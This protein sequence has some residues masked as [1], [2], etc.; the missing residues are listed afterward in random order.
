MIHASS[1][2]RVTRLTEYGPPPFLVEQVHLTVHLDVDPVLV[3][4]RLAI[5]RNPV[6]TPTPDLLLDGQELEMVALRLDGREPAAGSWMIDAAGNLLLRQVPDRF[7]LEVENRIH[8]ARNTSLEGLYLSN[9]RFCTQCEAEGFRKITWYLDR[10]DVLARFTV[11]LVAPCRGYPVLLA[12]GNRIAQG[13]LEGERHYATWE[14]PFPKPSYLF[15]MVAGDLA[16]ISGEFTTRSGRRVALHFYTEAENADRC[17]HALS[18]LK[19]AMAWDEIRFGREY[20]LDVYMIVAVNDFNM[21]AMEN[22]GLNIFNSQYVLAKP[23]TATD[24]DFQAIESVIAH[25]Y[26]HNWT[27]NRITCRDWFQLSLKE[28]LTVFRDQEFSADILSRGVQRIKDVRLL[29]TVQFA[30][31]SGPTAH[32]VQPDTYIEINNFYT[33]TIYNKGAEVVRMLHTLLGEADFRR[34]MDLYF[35]R[36]DG[37]AVTVD[38]FVRA[39]EEAS[40]RDFSQF[41]LWYRQAGT[42]I[43][44]AAMEYSVTT[45]MTT[46]TLSQETAPT[47]GQPD[48]KPLHIPVRVAL[49]GTTGEHLPLQDNHSAPAPLEMVLELREARQAFHF[50]GQAGLEQRPVVSILRGFSAP[51]RLEMARTDAELAFLWARDTDPFNRWDAGQE[52]LERWLFRWIGQY[53]QESRPSLVGDGAL[54]AAFLATLN[55]PGLDPAMRALAL[56]LPGEKYVLD[57]MEQANPDVVHAVREFLRRDLAEHLAPDLL[58]L[59]Q[60]MVV[61]TTG[62]DGLAAETTGA[63]GH[64]DES[65]LAAGRRALKNMALATLAAADQP[66]WYRL[67]EQQYHASHNMTDRMAALNVLVQAGATQAEAVLDDFYQQW[68]DDFLVTNK[69]LTLQ[70]SAPLAET[71]ERVLALTRHPVFNPNNPNRVRALI[72]GF[73]NGNPY[74]FHHPSGQGYRF[75]G[76]WI[77]RLDRS[78][79]QIAA[80]LLTPF[81]RWRFFEPGRSERMREVL[82]QIAEQATLS[83]DVG[84]MV[85]KILA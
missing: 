48:K 7:I 38:D 19:K 11:T 13:L 65:P 72:G 76:E 73:A 30:E 70:A 49:L 59:Y 35:A 12:N 42:P 17:D 5:R 10:P 39:M 3:Q 21:G 84:E 68:R 50:V 33:T 80:R 26:F 85:G 9:G 8:P 57:R 51:V 20:D 25:E 81:N 14:D 79:S 40:Q 24:E 27:G 61:E 15:A 4:A 83:R 58:R 23:S 6:A 74:C 41:R 29:R 67:C 47:P 43:V 64:H 56:T 52:L 16:Q 37:Q 55:D 62:A 32:P 69:W 53:R 31:D 46:L 44:R 36:H 45:G 71:F 34:G 78:N 75:L 1:A 18:A 77:M 2:S 60:R 82:Q 63:N 28:G 22:K 54:R 66:E